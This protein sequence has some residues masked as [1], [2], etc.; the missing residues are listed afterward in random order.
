MVTAM[1]RLGHDANGLSWSWV[2]FV[3]SDSKQQYGNRTSSHVDAHHL[4][5]EQL[6]WKAGRKRGGMGNESEGMSVIM[7]T[8]GPPPNQERGAHQQVDA[9]RA[10]AIQSHSFSSQFLGSKNFHVG[11][12]L[13]ISALP[14]KMSTSGMGTILVP[15]AHL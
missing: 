1:T 7:V 11:S 3:C 5:Y 9:T 14:D 12:R 4:L 6:G 13:S 8:T 10:H 2:D 15:L